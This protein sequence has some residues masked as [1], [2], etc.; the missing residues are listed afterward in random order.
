M[1]QARGQDVT[2]LMNS[3]HPGL[4]LWLLKMC[5]TSGNAFPCLSLPTRAQWPCNWPDKHHLLLGETSDLSQ[6]ESLG[7]AL[8]P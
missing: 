4:S 7:W 5:E 2:Y 8:G 1:G 3:Q 6:L